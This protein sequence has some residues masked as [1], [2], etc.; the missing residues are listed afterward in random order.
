[1]IKYHSATSTQRNLLRNADFKPID[2]VKFLNEDVLPE[3]YASASI[4]LEP[5]LMQ[6]LDSLASDRRPTAQ[7]QQPLQVFVNGRLRRVSKL[8]DSTSK[9]MKDVWQRSWLC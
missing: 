3:V 8:V 9:L 6:A 1:M 7:L 2:L 4:D 5:L